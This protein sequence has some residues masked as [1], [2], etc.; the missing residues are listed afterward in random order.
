MMTNQT[1]RIPLPKLVRVDSIQPRFTSE[2]D[3]VDRKHLKSLLASDP[4]SWPP[5]IV[6]PDTRGSYIIVDGVHRVTAAI[7][8]RLADIAAM[9]IDSPTETTARELAFDANRTHGLSFTLAER[10][11]HAQYLHE[12]HPDWTQRQIAAACDLSLGTTNSAL[13]R[14]VQSEQNSAQPESIEDGLVVR[15]IDDVA[16]SLVRGIGKLWSSRGLTELLSGP[17]RMGGK[18]A[19]ALRDVYGDDAPEWAA[20]FEAWAK[21]ARAELK[22]R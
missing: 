5:I 18:L 6:Y 15:S 21:T 22:G 9:V 3:W 7:E 13:K 10:K 20:R 8:M 14:S 12:Q 19:E 11:L 1:I 4:V 2:D 16:R 17:E